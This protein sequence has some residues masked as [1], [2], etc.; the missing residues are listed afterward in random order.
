MTNEIQNPNNKYLGF[1]TWIYLD[2]ISLR[3]R[4]NERDFEFRY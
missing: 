3:K 1:E 2:G 4:E